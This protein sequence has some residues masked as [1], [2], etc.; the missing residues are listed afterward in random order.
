MSPE[1]M[2]KAFCYQKINEYAF[3]YFKIFF[4]KTI[5]HFIE[6]FHSLSIIYLDN[7]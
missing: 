7:F 1:D 4:V 6:N 2:N 5:M 3:E